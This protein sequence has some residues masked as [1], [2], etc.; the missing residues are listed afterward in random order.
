MINPIQ[1]AYGKIEKSIRNTA[2]YY[3]EGRNVLIKCLIRNSGKT[4]VEVVRWLKVNNIP[5]KDLD[6]YV[7]KNDTD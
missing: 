5:V 2:K 1:L 6:D 7:I 4:E 3:I